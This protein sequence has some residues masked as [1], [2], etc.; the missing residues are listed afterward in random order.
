[1]MTEQLEIKNVHREPHPFV[2]V[3]HMPQFTG[4]TIAFV[5][6]VSAVEEG[7]MTMKSADETEIK[8]IRLKGEVD[9]FPVGVIVEVRGIVNKDGS[10]SFGEHSVYDAEFDLS[11]YENMLEYYHGMCKE[12]SVK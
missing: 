10:I 4:K 3:S 11:A 9:K 7:Q 5:G 2:G 12:L 8:I 1:M 6:R